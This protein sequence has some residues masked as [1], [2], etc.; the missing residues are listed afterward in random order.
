MTTTQDEQEDSNKRVA[1]YDNFLRAWI[2]NRMEVDKQLLTLSALAIGLLVSVFGKP[3]N[4]YEIVA[5]FFAG[6]SFLICIVTILISFRKNSDYVKIVLECQDDGR[7]NDLLQKE[8]QMSTY[9][10]KLFT[11]STR[12]FSVGVISTATLAVLRL[13]IFKIICG[14]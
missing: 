5:W 13:D 11:F 8:K 7:N 12:L 10:K 9:S 3:S 6:I 4:T 1:Y 14:S 2:E